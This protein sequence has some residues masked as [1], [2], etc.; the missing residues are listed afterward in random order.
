MSN[1]L[2]SKEIFKEVKQIE[3]MTSRL[4][5]DIFAGEYHSVFKGQ[6]IEFDEVREYQPG[7]DIRTIDWNVT[8]R[9]RKVHVK[10]FIEER[11]LTVMLVVDASSSLR[12]GS[13]QTLKNN[14]AVQIASVLALSAIRNNDKVGL[15]IFTS[16]IELY[17]PPRKG[18]QHVLRMIREILF[19]KP[20]NKGTDHVLALEYLGKVQKRKTI[21]FLISDFMFFDTSENY[22][23]KRKDLKKVMAVANRRH[24]LIGIVLHDPK[25]FTIKNHGLLMI[26]DAETGDLVCVDTTDT[27]FCR[28]YEEHNKKRYLDQKA[29]LRSVSMDSVDIMTDASFA[30]ELVKFFVKRKKRKR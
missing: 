30:D 3:I 17:I 18:R 13:V 5:A 11:E 4:V 23:T 15:I 2:I 8:A 27:R 16:T 29:L 20:K 26:E 21:T 25:E 10:Q 7:D 19:F 14:I 22:A 24:D 28:E 9:T 1:E 6:G 12:F